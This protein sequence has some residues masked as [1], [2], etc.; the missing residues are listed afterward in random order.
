MIDLDAMREALTPTRN[1]LDAAGFA[2][3]LEEQGNH[4]RLTVIAGT[5][6]CEDCLVPKSLFRQMVS[7]EIGAAGL[8][9]VELEIVYPLD[10]RRNRA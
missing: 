9:P 2:L 8:A 1:G 6:A 10:T 4:L 5:A 3:S 7:D